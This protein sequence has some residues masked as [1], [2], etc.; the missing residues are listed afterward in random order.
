[1][2]AEGR[3]SGATLVEEVSLGLSTIDVRFKVIGLLGALLTLIAFG[4][5]N[6]IIPTPFFERPIAPEP[7]AI[8]TWIVSAPL[9]GF[10][11]ATYLSPPK[12]SLD[13][14]TP[15]AL[16]TTAASDQRSTL[17]VLGGFGTLLAIGCPICN[18]IALVLLGTSGALS[19]YAPLQPVI[20]GISIALLVATAVWRLRLRARGNACVVPV[21][22]RPD[23]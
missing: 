16:N 3:H 13:P 23:R 9:I 14:A 10:V 2:S 19:V 4:V 7:F 6:A 12:P 11:L 15:L 20:G 22:G 17:G 21:V 8:A 5:L 18:K 1:M